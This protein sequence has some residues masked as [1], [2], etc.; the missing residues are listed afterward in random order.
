MRYK[1]K[2]KITVDVETTT[3]DKISVDELKFL[4]V[5]D[6]KDAGF[7]VYDS[8]VMPPKR[9]PN[10]DGVLELSK[11]EKSVFAQLVG[12]PDVSVSKVY[13]K[14]GHVYYDFT[15]GKSIVPYRGKATNY[16]AIEWILKRFN[17]IGE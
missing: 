2:A 12:D 1:T 16:K 14:G 13:I 11:E 3:T 6:I 5:E 10:P 7:H 4:V 17:L 9:L 8:K 15:Y